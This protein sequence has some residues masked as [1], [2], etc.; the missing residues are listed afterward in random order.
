M[1]S[2]TCYSPMVS[3][4]IGVYSSILNVRLAVCG[5]NPFSP[6]ITLGNNRFCSILNLP[7]TL[8]SS[9]GCEI[10]QI[11]AF[12]IDPS[13][14]AEYRIIG[15]NWGQSNINRQVEGSSPSRPTIYNTIYFK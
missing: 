2:G 4:H 15:N 6:T 8:M 7:N 3:Q 1:V 13:R 12:A 10:K 9:F 5:Y 14:A 11:F